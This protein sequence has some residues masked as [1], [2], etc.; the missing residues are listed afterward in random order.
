MWYIYKGVILTKDNLINYNWNGN[1][2]CSF[3]CKDESIQQLF[4]CLYARFVW[5]L[6]H[7]TFGI[8]PPVNTNE[9]IQLLAGASVF[10]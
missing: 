3:C 10:C 2:Q 7:I 1:K 9:R 4:Y 5:G 8:P 6:V